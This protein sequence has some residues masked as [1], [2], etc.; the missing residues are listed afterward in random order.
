MTGIGKLFTLGL[1]AIS[2]ACLA[3]EKIEIND[4]KIPLSSY[5]FIDPNIDIK[6]LSAENLWN[7]WESRI[8][9]LGLQRYFP[10][11]VNPMDYQGQIR[12]DLED[13]VMDAY[14]IDYTITTRK[15]EFQSGPN[16]EKLKRKAIALTKFVNNWGEN[17]DI[18]T[19]RMEKKP[20]PDEKMIND[21]RKSKDILMS[22]VKNNMGSYGKGIKAE[23]SE[24]TTSEDIQAFIYYLVYNIICLLVVLFALLIILGIIYFLFSPFI[25]IIRILYRR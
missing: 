6:K 7:I 8:S 14:R 23:T 13:F 19:R 1:L 3:A 2:S 4:S 9:S 20:V 24:E 15:M 10:Q 5:R 16:T 17:V 18:F 25:K 21:I 12:F 22:Y 11:Y